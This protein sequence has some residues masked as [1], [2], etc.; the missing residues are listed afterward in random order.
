MVPLARAVGKCQ[1][2]VPSAL[3][4]ELSLPVLCWHTYQESTVSQLMWKEATSS[5][6]SAQVPREPHGSQTRT[7]RHA[8]G[9]AQ[10]PGPDRGPGCRGTAVLAVEGEP[11]GDRSARGDAT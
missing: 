1:K 3:S 9:I 11:H 6:G 5:A 10:R 4:S 2:E 7:W 8:P